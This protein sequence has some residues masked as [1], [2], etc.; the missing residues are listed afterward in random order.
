MSLQVKIC[1]ITSA[2]D[3]QTAVQAGADLIGLVFYEPSARAVTVE[4]AAAIARTIP[5]TVVRVGLFVNPDPGRVLEAIS[6]CGLQMLQFHGD[7]SPDFCRQF[8][9]LTMKAFRIQSAETLDVLRHYPADA[10]LLDAHVPGQY[11]G[12]GRTFD[13]ALAARATQLGKPVFLAGGLTP[14]NVAEAVRTVRPYGVD[15]SGGVEAAPGRKDPAKVRAF[16]SAAKRAA[17]EQT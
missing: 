10:W 1:G 13:W 5:P 7:E 12:T 8:G 15:V 17:G 3:A 16:I 4:S 14:D 2:V 6:A 9:L 11:G